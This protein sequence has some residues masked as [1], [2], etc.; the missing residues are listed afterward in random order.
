M[1][2]DKS[3]QSTIA[4]SKDLVEALT[5]YL[6]TKSKI[7]YLDDIV[8][9][10]I[11][12]LS[13]GKLYVDIEEDIQEIKL[14]ASGWPKSHIKSLIE[15]GWIDGDSSPITLINNRLS[16]RRWHLEM[17]TAIKTLLKKQKQ[18]PIIKRKTSSTKTDKL[19]KELNIEQRSAV[20]A[21]EHHNVILLSGGPGTGKTSTIIKMILKAISSS[22]NL[23]IGLAAPTGKA[24]R[25][26]Q[27]SLHQSI[28]SIDPTYQEV[29]AK[30]P[31]QT[32]HS[33]LKANPSGFRKNKNSPLDLDL[34]VVDEMSMVDLT[35]MK[36]LLEA[37]PFDSQLV[38]VGDPNQL[39]PIGIGSIWQ[40]LHQENNLTDF[41][42]AAIKLKKLYRNRGE[43]ASLGQIINNDG[44][45]SFW[46]NVQTLK[47]SSNVIF[48]I[49][50][51][52]DIPEKVLNHLRK[53][54]EYLKHFT[55]EL[56]NTLPEDLILL[57]NPSTTQ[58]AA[59]KHLFKALGELMVL[60]PK[61]NGLWGVNHVHQVLLGNTFK[62]DAMRWPEGTPVM[63]TENQHE[64]GLSNG[65]IGIVIGESERQRLL[66]M[67]YTN[68]NKSIASFFHPARLKSIEP[69]LA[70]TIHKAQGSE[71]LKVIVLWPESIKENQTGT[72]NEIF[73]QRLLYTAITRAKA[74]LEINV[75]QT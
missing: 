16:W 56:K 64:L 11:D 65:D 33:W 4:I 67:V 36:A 2:L 68:E 52:K 19:M 25:R 44:L 35:L 15:S 75:N 59:I 30:I 53:Q 72:A 55:S 70:M 29:L 73:E 40:E 74:K 71:A 43:L 5:R 58:S 22:P 28:S 1:T 38:L 24:A 63:C 61:R 26:L 32:L 14:K 62:E 10:L 20:I 41:G 31:C 60:C 47:P 57:P 9:L 23:R 45:T 49:S 46:E 13:K 51:E 7:E 39:P 34:L 8:T 42:S 3:E 54:S 69:A 21:L 50:I 6:P 37:L 18:S 48:N 12:A 17:D 66:F 27:E